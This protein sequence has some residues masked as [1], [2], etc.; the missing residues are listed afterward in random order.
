[1]YPLQGVRILDLTRLL[2]GPFCT[3]VLAALGAEVL[4]VEDPGVGDY[5][6]LW[7]PMVGSSGALFHQLNRGK[8]SIIIDLRQAEGQSL[9]REL[10]GGSDIL[11]EGF[12]PG[13]LAKLGVAPQDLRREFPRLI[14]CSIS[15]YGQDGPRSHRAGHS[16]NYEAVSGLLWLNGEQG[17]PPRIPGF[18]VAD[19]AGAMQAALGMTAALYQ[20]ERT[21]EGCWIDISMTESVASLT[22]PVQGF[23]GFELEE[24]RGLGML[25]GGMACYHVYRTADGEYLTV[26][27]IEPKFWMGVCQLLELPGLASLPAYPGP[28][29]PE[30]IRRVTEVVAS[31]TRAQWEKTFE[32]ADLCVEPVLSPQEAVDD[33]H[34]QHRCVV[35]EGGGFRWFRPPLGSSPEGDPPVAGEHTDPVLQEMG[36]SSDRIKR[37]RENGVVH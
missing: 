26:A 2:P 19:L 27:A 4:R 12:R 9:L 14:L 33:A 34:A 18:P 8:R 1:M 29:Q 5:A 32:G 21:S 25:T 35:E 30:A 36:Y 17:G 11:V 23:R 16:L 10:A 13:T 28:A 7:P 37:L 31:K 15:G 6:R 20:R 22:A 24:D 3:W